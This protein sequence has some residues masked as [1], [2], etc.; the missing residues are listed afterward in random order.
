MSEDLIHE[1]GDVFTVGY[2]AAHEKGHGDTACTRAGLRA[3]LS[4]LAQ[5]GVEGLPSVDWFEQAA[6]MVDGPDDAQAMRESVASAIT[7]LLAARDAALAEARAERNL[8]KRYADER[9]QKEDAHR[10]RAETAEK[11]LAGVHD[12]LKDWRGL[13]TSR[14][15]GTDAKEGL[16][17]CIKKLAKALDEGAVNDAPISDPAGRAKAVAKELRG[18]G[19]KGR[20]M[21]NG[22]E[23]DGYWYHMA[24][25]GIAH[26]GAGTIADEIQRQESERAKK[27]AG[28]T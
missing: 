6:G 5:R 10:A 8:Y 13:M 4:C 1:L 2:Q 21:G 23:V 24:W 11:R 25:E 18:R 7:P 26:M 9:F 3:V 20:V 14:T 15:F 17:Y 28:A 22:I 27:W 16:E 19:I 12:L